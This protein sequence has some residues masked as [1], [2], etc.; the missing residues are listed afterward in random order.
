MHKRLLVSAGLLVA[1]LLGSS[2]AFAGDVVTDL[3]KRDTK[4]ITITGTIEFDTV[5]REDFFDSVFPR[6]NHPAPYHKGTDQDE[7]FINPTL[8]LR[9]KAELPDRF[10]GILELRTLPDAYGA[11]Q[12]LL[13]TDSNRFHIQQAS[14][15]AE[16]F[17]GKGFSLHLGILPVEV[18][19]RDNGDAFFMNVGESESPFTGAVHTNPVTHFTPLSVTGSPHPGGLAGSGYE[20]NPFLG[21]NAWWNNY[22]GQSKCSEFGGFGLRYEIGTPEE[23]DFSLDVYGGFT[24]ETGL[25]GVDN[26]LFL[27]VPALHLDLM[28]EGKNRSTVQAVAAMIQ[29]DKDTAVGAL[30]FGFDLWLTPYEDYWFEFFFEYMGQFGEYTSETRV[31]AHDKTHQAAHAFYA[32]LRFEPKI[33]KEPDFRPFFEFSYWW[34]SGDDGNP[35]DTNRD[36]LSFEDVD[37]LLIMESNDVGLDVDCNYRAL[38]WELGFKLETFEFSVRYGMFYLIHTPYHSYY[39]SPPG[40]RAH[41][42]KLLGNEVDVRFSFKLQEHLTVSAVACILF[43][44]QFWDQSTEARGLRPLPWHGTGRE[45]GLGLLEVKLEF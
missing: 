41:F 24:M 21:G 1:V 43:D 28:G 45:A 32:G 36:F 13:G 31:G 37:T 22:S 18:D 27:A 39:G 19:L 35:L 38:K 44:A 10:F 9:F 33:L 25:T 42:S 4:L 26:F 8:G 23:A 2:Q 12:G 16:E 29:G 5:W 3:T 40:G 30:G 11:E 34:I 14:I 7:L 17:L 6:N 20:W 15:G